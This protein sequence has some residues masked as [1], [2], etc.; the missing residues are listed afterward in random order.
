MAAPT[1]FIPI[2]LALLFAGCLGAPMAQDP[3]VEDGPVA[4]PIEV[5]PLREPVVASRAGFIVSRLAGDGPVRLQFQ[6]DC[7]VFFFDVPASTP[8][9]EATLRWASPA[10]NQVV[11][12][13]H[14]VNG[15]HVQSW[16]SP[17]EMDSSP[18]VLI[19]E[20]PDPGLW[21]GYLGPGIAGGAIEWDL[22]LT[23]I[24]VGESAFQALPA[25]RLRDTDDC[26]R[27]RPG[28]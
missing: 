11:M 3:P 20:H 8:R 28:L 17:A 22:E 6:G 26:E 2:V 1:L 24:G 21:Y 5:S 18:I 27:L 23:W 12:D 7:P 19:A 9:L 16:E 13:L 4:A 15:S 10:P 14:S 25:E